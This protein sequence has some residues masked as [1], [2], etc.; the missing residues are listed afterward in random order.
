M[1]KTI[2][3][4]VFTFSFLTGT[5]FSADNNI[6]PVKGSYTTIAT[7]TGKPFR[8]YIAGSKKAKQG[9]LLLHGW[10]GLNHEME[11]WADRFADQGYRVMAIDLYNNKTTNHPGTGRKLMSNINKKETSDKYRAAIKLLSQDDRKVAVLGRGFGANQAIHAATSNRHISAVVLFYPFGY[12]GKIPTSLNAPI[13]GN[14]AKKNYFFNNELQ[15]KFISAAN[16]KKIDLTVETYPARH[17]FSNMLG[18]NFDP[19]ADSSSLKNTLTF[20]DKHLR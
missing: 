8:A 9:L 7:E 12:V 13:L 6:Q 15:K 18:E 14:F 16:Q 3:S 17:G 10:R 2:F 1:F 19:D 20:L 4:I 11:L 5:A